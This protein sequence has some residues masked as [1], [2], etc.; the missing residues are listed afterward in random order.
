MLIAWLWNCNSLGSVRPHE[1]SLRNALA[2]NDSISVPTQNN[3]G[4]GMSSGLSNVQIIEL[5]NL[6]QQNKRLQDNTGASAN[7]D[8][9]F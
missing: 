5:E 2:N 6:K 7:A 1:S 8:V 4:G 9:I 3:L